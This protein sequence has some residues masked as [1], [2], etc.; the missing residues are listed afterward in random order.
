MVRDGILNRD[1]YVRCMALHDLQEWHEMVGD[2]RSVTPI[3]Q[4]RASS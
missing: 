3:Y 2:R 4:L 1:A